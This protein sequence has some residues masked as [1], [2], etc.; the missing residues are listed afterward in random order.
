MTA[1]VLGWMAVTWAALFA[2]L[3]M[4]WVASGVITPLTALQ[5]DIAVW[6][7]GTRYELPVAITQECSGADALAFCFGA[8][9]AFPVSWRRRLVGVA[10]AFAV[11]VPLNVARIGTLVAASPHAELFRALHLY[12]WPAT[13]ALAAAAYFASWTR[14]ALV[15]AAVWR[16]GAPDRAFE[17]FVLLSA[18]LLSAFALLAPWIMASAAVLAACAW[19]ASAAVPLLRLA[20]IAASATGNVLWTDRGSFLVA[21]ECVATPLLPVYLAAVLALPLPRRNRVLWTIAAIPL[22]VGLGVVRLLVLALPPAL[23]AQPL[24]LA[25]GFYQLLVFVVL[26]AA[27]A[28]WRRMRNAEPSPRADVLRAVVRAVFLACLVALVAGPFY[29]GALLRAASA[30]RALAPHTVCTLAAPG[31][32]QGALAIL[33]TYQLALLVGLIAASG[34]CAGSRRQAAALGLLFAAQLALL[35]VFGEIS[36]RAGLG[37]PAL[38]VR[39]A[40]VC[41]P[42]AVV[43][44]IGTPVIGPRA[45]SLRRFWTEVGESFP[46]LGGAA[47]TDYYFENE[48]RLLLEQLPAMSGCRLLKT[49]L[50]DEAK[51]TRILN[52]AAAQGARAFGLDISSPIVLLARAG[53][54]GRVLHGLHADVRRLPFG[55]ASFDAVYSMGTIEHFDDSAAAVCEIFRV[56]R[57]GGRVILGVP[58]RHDPFL[59]PLLV[60]A[61]SSVGLYGY[62]YER[63]FT[64]RQ[65]RRMLEGAGFRVLDETGILFIPCWL[66]MLDLAAHAWWPPLTRATAPAVRVF[67]WIDRRFPSVRRHGYLLA[68]VAERP[69]R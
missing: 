26:V 21:Q 18:A 50:W 12:I 28:S 48:R 42:L 49:D 30:L 32:V 27:A 68:S 33:P 47:S 64:R 36:A 51:N 40:A 61:L 20:G 35:A 7:A 55:D 43:G 56:L 46:D 6:Y 62:G 69:L 53:F 58:N 60:A 23:S 59:R 24:F 34:C 54:D 2:L 65:L 4:P 16:H 44:L 5:G 17:R 11:I 9:V 13:I 10:G 52:W 37:A 63:S 25:H 38:V 29:V 31:D 39:I 19:V 41:V 14:P 66:R 67:A 45:G 1:R 15:R 22:F 3:R 57:P 8:I